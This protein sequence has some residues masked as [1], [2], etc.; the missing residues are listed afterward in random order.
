M[1]WQERI[2]VDPQIL[3]GKPVRGLVD[4]V[5]ASGH[6]ERRGRSHA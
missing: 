2:I 4:T 1:I 6:R 5:I 3:V